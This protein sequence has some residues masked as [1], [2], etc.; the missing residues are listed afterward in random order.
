MLTISDDIL[1]LK[2]AN[3]KLLANLDDR[4]EKRNTTSRYKDANGYIS[5]IFCIQALLRAKEQN[6]KW[7]QNLVN[8][9]LEI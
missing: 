1:K 8:A 3:R 6:V 7:D 2:K 9:N 4:A 5:S